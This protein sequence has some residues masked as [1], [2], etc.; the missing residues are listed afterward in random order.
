MAR[1]DRNRGRMG[2]HGMTQRYLDQRL[3]LSLLRAVDAVEAHRSLLAASSALGITQPALTKSLQEL[4]EVVGARLFDRHSRGVR[5]TEAGQVFVEAARRVLAEVRR[6]DDQLDHLAS[7]GGGTVALGAL[8]VAAAG[9][10]PGT[11]G[12]LKS[13]NPQIRVR[14]QEGRTGD[15]LP[16]LASGEI[17]LI[18][19]QLYEPTLP[20]RFVREPLWTEPISILARREHPIF[21]EAVTAEAL[22]GYDLVL[23]TVSQRIGLEI[24]HLLALLGLQRATSL[25]SSSYGFIREMLHA[26]DLISVMP[27]LMLVGDLLR[28][29]LKVVPLPIPAPERR[30]GLILCRERVLPPAGRALVQCLRAFITEIA[31]LGLV[32]IAGGYSVAETSDRTGRPDRG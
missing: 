11:L 25:R 21:A 16:L 18:V 22:R 30:A 8:P 2:L 12:R 24:E 1:E 29:T 28:G 26:T 14:L 15:L 10:L 27:R 4:E 5:P 17:D 3:R 31:A 6:L 20:D 7:P 23:P 9:I 13:T 32:D 19:G